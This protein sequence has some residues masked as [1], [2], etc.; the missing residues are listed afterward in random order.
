MFQHSKKQAGFTFIELIIA[1][2]LGIVVMGGIY[3]VYNFQNKTYKT[4]QQGRASRSNKTRS[5]FIFRPLT[6][7]FYMY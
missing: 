1:M 2:V 6:I 4:Q 3:S 5:F 7:W